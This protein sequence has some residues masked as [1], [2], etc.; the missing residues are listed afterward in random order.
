VNLATSLYRRLHWLNLPGALLVALLQR[1]PVLRFAALAEEAVVGSRVAAIVRSSFTAAASLGA[2]QALAGATQFQI[3]RALPLTGT[4]GTTFQ[5]FS[6]TITGAPSIVGSYRLTGTLPPGLTL[7]GANSSGIVNTTIGTISG[8][9]QT[10]GSYTV[11]I[12]AYEFTNATG[13]AFGPLNVSFTIAAA[14][15]PPAIVA[16]P[17][18]KIAAAGGSVTLSV[19]ATGSPAPSYQWQRNGVNVSSGGTSSSLTLSNLQPAD[20]GLYRVVVTNSAGSVTS[21]PAIVGLTT[22]SKVIGA[23]EEIGPNILHPNGHIYDQ[24]L[25]EG[26]SASVTAD[27]DQ[28]LRISYIDLNDDIVQ[29]EF[30]GHGTLTLSLDNPIG[31]ATPL[32]YNQGVAYMKGHANIVIA[33]ADEFSNVTIFS[34]GKLNAL[35]QALFRDDVTYD[36]FADIAF[37]AI[38]SANGKFG[39]LRSANAHYFATAGATGVYAPGVEFV[40]P[41]PVLMG[42]I[43]SFDAA[44]PYILL[45]SSTDT[46]ING[47]DLFQPNGQ[48]VQVSGF[49]QLKFVNGSSSHGKLYPAQPNQGTLDDNTGQNVTTQL[50][51]YPPQ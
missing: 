13:D 28:V 49:S 9:P 24:V 50:V 43:S 14:T 17:S 2:V 5:S 6:F 46:Q 51:V 16:Q 12:R 36:G 44:R 1:T 41:S 27:P 20:V 38:A 32:F 48:H 25:L 29:V 45:G 19:S 42:N 4:V 31:P 37:V 22:S 21:Q 30:A 40:A 34:V 33:D 39:G 35:N 26:G 7:Q 3:T 15:A 8:T 11:A 10:A 18:T 47:G 23:A